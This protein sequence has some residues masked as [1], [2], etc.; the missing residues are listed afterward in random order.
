MSQVSDPFQNDLRGVLA[1][2]LGAL[3]RRWRWGLL[4]LTCLSALAFWTSQYIPRKYQAV[5]VFERRDDAVLQ[6]LVQQNSPYGFDHLKSSLTLDLTGARARADAAMAIGLLPPGSLS[7]EGPLSPEEMQRLDSVLSAY[8]LTPSVRMLTSVPALDVI[9]LRAT[10]ASPEATRRFVNA[11]RDQYIASTRQRI[12]DVLEGTRNFFQGQLDGYLRKAAEAQVALDRR[13]ADFPGL[14]PRDSVSLG[15]RLEAIRAERERA[16]QARDELEAQISARNEFLRDSAAALTDPAAPDA[17][18]RAADDP[19]A[20]LEEKARQI[21]QE[22]TDAIVVRQ[23]TLEHPAV[24]ALQRKLDALNGVRESFASATPASN[25]SEPAAK[26]KPSRYAIQVQLEVDALQ[27]QLDVVR[28]RAEEVEDRAQRFEALYRQLTEDSG[29]LR[30]IEEEID[31]SAAAA[32]VWR[33]HLTQ[34]EQVMAAEAGERGTRFSLVEEP[35]IASPALSPKLSA[36]FGVCG[37]IGLAAAIGVIALLEL[38]DR[39]IR[40]PSQAARVLAIPAVEFVGAVA[41]P[42]MRRRRLISVSIWGP[43]LSFSLLC[44][45]AAGGLAYAS[46]ARPA[47]YSRQIQKLEPVLR[48]LGIPTPNL[49]QERG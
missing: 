37:A 33:H 17:T 3:R 1:E 44:L 15:A 31:Q 2:Y 22:I 5:T 45:L 46:V 11:L 39:S 34:L 36:I 10:G 4:A 43:A 47:F 30:G 40:T 14:R 42:A 28:R 23:M 49:L 12:N 26:P 7:A 6:N 18:A 38:M 21:Q 32:N 24:R 16:H 29:E 27:R 35:K 25:P 41:T 9:E 48:G 8:G 19:A 13:F 20:L